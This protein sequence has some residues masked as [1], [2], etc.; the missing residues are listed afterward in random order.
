[1]T[2]SAPARHCKIQI[3][4]VAD[5]LQFAESSKPAAT[6]KQN[7]SVII[8]LEIS[9]QQIGGAEEETLFKSNKLN[10]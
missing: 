6:T 3:I 1:V 5:S 2:A 8:Q 7:K 4:G 10:Q 9:L